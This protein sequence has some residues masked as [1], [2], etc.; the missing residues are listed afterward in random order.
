[1]AAWIQVEAPPEGLY[2]SALQDPR[3]PRCPEG[4]SM[5]TQESSYVVALLA[6][7][8]VAVLVTFFALF[9][10]V[11]GLQIFYS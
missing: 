4:G 3:L 2:P 8:T 9:K 6:A 1:M 11:S 7:L 10:A 5:F